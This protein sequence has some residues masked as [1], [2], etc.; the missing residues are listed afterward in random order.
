MSGWC[1]PERL[2]EP[3][4]IASAMPTYHYPL[5]PTAARNCPVLRSGLGFGSRLLQLVYFRALVVVCLPTGRPPSAEVKLSSTVRI[6][7][8][9][10]IVPLAVPKDRATHFE[11]CRRVKKKRM[12]QKE[13]AS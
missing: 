13:A 4:P 9:G 11:Y 10:E 7:P 12:A 2:G 1:D 5:C 3:W 8:S 6:L